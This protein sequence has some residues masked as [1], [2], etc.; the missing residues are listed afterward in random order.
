MKEF[1]KTKDKGQLY[2]DKVLFESNIPILFVCKNKEEELFLCVCCQSNT[3]GRKWL[4]SSVDEETIIHLLSDEISIRDAL[5]KDESYRLSVICND[6]GTSMGYDASDWQEDSK[7]LPKKGAYMEADEGEFEE[8][9]E[10]YYLKQSNK[11]YRDLF[12]NI[13]SGSKE[14]SSLGSYIVN[15]ENLVIPEYVE[16]QFVGM[17]I[18]AM[19]TTEI[20]RTFGGEL[21][22]KFDD[23]DDSAYNQ[24]DCYFVSDENTVQVTIS[25][26]GLSQAA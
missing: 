19:W 14:V 9:L 6:S 12:E 16:H 22:S 24:T 10:Y 26:M 4:I 17:Q 3:S 21:N 18:E 1:V 23:I 2:I 20:K 8:E 5:L 7:Y 25:D 13:L 15:T 11:Q